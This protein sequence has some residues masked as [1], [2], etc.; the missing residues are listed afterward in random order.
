MP[1]ASAELLAIDISAESGDNRPAQM[2]GETTAENF[3][4]Y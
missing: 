2:D 3:K 1:Q 4:F